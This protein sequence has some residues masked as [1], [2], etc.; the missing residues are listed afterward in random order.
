MAARERERERQ[1][2]EER[3]KPAA[4]AV[5]SGQPSHLL[6]GNRR[7]PRP[8]PQRGPPPGSSREW[9]RPR[10]RGGLFGW[11][12][13]QSGTKIGAAV[14]WSCTS[15]QPP[16]R[17]FQR[18]SEGP[19]APPPPLAASPRAT[20]RP[21]AA[22]RG[23]CGPEPPLEASQRGAS[24]AGRGRPRPRR[25]PRGPR[26]RRGDN[27]RAGAG[28][29]RAQGSQRRP[30]HTCARP[31]AEGRGHRAGRAA[32]GALEASPLARPRGGAVSG[33]EPEPG[34]R[35]RGARKPLRRPRGRAPG[36]ERPRP[37]PSAFSPSEAER[38]EVSLFRDFFLCSSISIVPF[39]ASPCD[40][41]GRQ[42]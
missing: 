27:G 29:G 21:E 20:P 7:P 10:P 37:G 11:R 2:Q 42:S 4:R 5:S 26:Q 8:C 19:E 13:E 33:R 18:W 24:G 6:R 35:A 3:G 40:L 23:R 32:R 41:K 15:R 38:H 34:A 28:P 12:R 39:L 17:L 1:S 16:P 31:G 25:L 22:A 14:G 36:M 9:P 30:P